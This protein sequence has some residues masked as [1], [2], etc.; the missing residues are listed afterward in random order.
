[1][2][3]AKARDIVK[4][5]GFRLVKVDGEYQVRVPG[6]PDATYF[7]DDLDDALWTARAMFYWMVTEG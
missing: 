7:T 3:L 4:G 6:K 5:Y 2:T 1:M